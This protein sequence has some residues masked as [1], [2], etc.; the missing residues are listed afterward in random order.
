MLKLPS[1]LVDFHR[2]KDFQKWVKKTF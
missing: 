2:K 1:Y